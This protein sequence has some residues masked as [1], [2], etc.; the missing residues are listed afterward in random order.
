MGT[1]SQFRQVH[2]SNPFS[3]FDPILN[4]GLSRGCVLE[5]TCVTIFEGTNFAGDSFV[6]LPP[7]FPLDLVAR[8]DRLSS[9][10]SGSLDLGWRLVDTTIAKQ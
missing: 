1:F 4:L 3:G 7:F 9:T 10:V 6:V 5:I 2:V 8:F